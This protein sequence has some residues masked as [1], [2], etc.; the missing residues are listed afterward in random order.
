LVHYPRRWKV[1][2]NIFGNNF[3]VPWKNFSSLPRT[4]CTL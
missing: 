1:N 4:I 2:V 3:Q